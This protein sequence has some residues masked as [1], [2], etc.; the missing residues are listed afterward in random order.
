MLEEGVKKT[1]L[2]LHKS[3]VMWPRMC[4][5]VWQ[6]LVGVESGRDRERGKGWSNKDAFS[7]IYV[8]LLEMFEK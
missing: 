2:S 8:S 6:E 4:L 1:G 5:G 7:A 3:E